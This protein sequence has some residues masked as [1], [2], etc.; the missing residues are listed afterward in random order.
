MSREPTI[1][2]GLDS[3]RRRFAIPEMPRG[4]EP[5]FL[6]S[7]GW[8]SGSTLV[9]RL[10]ASSGE[11][12]MWGE[13]Y[14]HCGLIRSLSESLRAFGE[15][16]PPVNPRG[17]WPPAGYLVDPADPPRGNRWIAN[18]YP[19]PADLLASHRAFFDRLFELPAVA[20]GF[21][22]WGIKAV[23]LG[24]E[25]AGYLQVLYPDARF[26]FLHRNPWDAWSSYRRRHD[27]REAAYWWF[28]RWPDEQVSD[29]E[30]FSKLWRQSTESFLT[31]SAVVGASIVAYEDVVSG[32]ALDALAHAAGVKVKKKTLRKRIGGA[33]ADRSIEWSLDD[34]DSQA[35]AEQA[36]VVARRLGYVGPME[37]GA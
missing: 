29:A 16:W 9:Q 10:L 27:E 34:E 28:H 32:D 8:R 4:S 37:A 19:H 25:H 11:L 22:R 7:A 36:G 13:P 17:D 2:D 35:I 20:G 23:R 1:T 15:P 6:M 33:R 30:H 26:I 14:D 21:A 24:G 3:L 18:A 31:W 5:V 12:L